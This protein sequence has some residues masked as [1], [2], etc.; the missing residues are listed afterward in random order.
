MEYIWAREHV[1][2]V[3]IAVAHE[4]ERFGLTVPRGDVDVQVCMCRD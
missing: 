4:L 1:E 3:Q 2:A